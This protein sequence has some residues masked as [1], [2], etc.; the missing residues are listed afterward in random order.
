MPENYPT[1][2][3]LLRGAICTRT[4]AQFAH[5]ADISVTHLNR[6]L[7]NET[8]FRPKKETLKKIAAAAKN[9][10]TFQ[11][12]QNALEQD[13]P[14]H[15]NDE[16]R[17]ASAQEDFKPE[18]S[19]LAEQTMD[20]LARIT[21][22]HSYPAIADSLFGFVSDLL[23]LARKDKPDNLEVAFELGVCRPYFGHKE[24]YAQKY[25]TVELTMA[26]S[27][28][29]A[30]SMMIL[31]YMDVPSG[32]G[33]AYAIQNADLSVEAVTDIFGVPYAA[34]ERHM[35][36]GKDEGDAIDE[37]ME[38]PFY[39]NIQ[40]VERFVERYRDPEAKSDGDKFLS[41]LLGK[42]FHYS[43]TLE[44]FGFYLDS[45]PRNFARFV[46]GHAECILAEYDNQPQ[47]HDEL[48][49]I[50]D[51]IRPDDNPED[52]AAK[53]DAFAYETSCDREEGW[54]LAIS[55]VMRYETGF[56]FAA[57][58]HS[59]DDSFPGL[60]DKDCIIITEDD[61][62]RANIQR[63]TLVLTVCRYAKELGISKFG[64]IMFTFV[65]TSFRKP[66]TYTV[67]TDAG[68]DEENEPDLASMEYTAKLEDGAPNESGLYAV[69]LKDGRKMR[70]VYIKPQNVWILRHVEWSDMIAAYCP[71][72]LSKTNSCQ[73][74]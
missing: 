31:Y 70:C 35:S 66:H 3:S 10:I 25:V 58:K 5:D 14:G 12:L 48:A 67:R 24:P 69:L 65:A 46:K 16:D 8:I 7:N 53:F 49:A 17:L 30:Q 1:F 27:K 56:S 64:D 21:S 37:A 38:D 19:E 43:L 73:R 42:E 51:G 2:R 57:E 20:S 63:E 4:Q 29:A 9:G 34:I 71:Q 23:D 55:A 50:I 11:D 28:N 36:D 59:E 62:T 32:K 74:Q 60:S 54:Q 40:P 18:F 41:M 22:E 15:A 26:D 61:Y 45:A 44:G 6:M 39:L 33:Q 13:D 47:K 72:M 52:V 68:V